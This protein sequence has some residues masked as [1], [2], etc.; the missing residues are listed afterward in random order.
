MQTK[1][2]VLIPAYNP[3]DN[4]IDVVANATSYFEQV[5]I[6]NDG[7]ADLFQALFDQVVENPA[8]KLINQDINQ[9]QGAAVKT[10]LA[11]ILKQHPD[12]EA[13]ITLDA[14]GQ[15]LISD[16]LKM[17]EMHQKVPK[18]ILFGA[19]SFDK[20][21]PFRSKFG[22][23]LTKYVFKWLIG[24]SISDTQTGMR[25]IPVEYIR[26]LLKINENRMDFAVGFLIRCRDAKIPI[27][28]CPIETVYI[29]GN[30]SSHFRPIID[31]YRI[32]SLLL[33]AGFKR[34][35]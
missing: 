17:C 19:R 31:S 15:H 13:V 11:Y 25:L 1:Q 3:P 20:D 27:S 29:D 16:A 18:K 10:G 8:V 5:F 4:F 26:E 22:N 35:K 23:I 30:H 6:V 9:G 28:E 12:I 32:Y 14:D 7:S 34:S 33:C 21:V 2:T 24:L